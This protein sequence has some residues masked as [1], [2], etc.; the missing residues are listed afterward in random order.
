MQSIVTNRKA[1]K[2]VGK[3][4]FLGNGTE[5]NFEKIVEPADVLVDSPDLRCAAGSA[6]R[7]SLASTV[8][9]RNI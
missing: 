2:L 3:R 1:A 4:D 5:A 8:C 9:A 7:Q 6:L